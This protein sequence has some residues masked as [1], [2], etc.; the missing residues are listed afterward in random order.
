MAMTS[1]MAK[2]TVSALAPMK[3]VEKMNAVVVR[4]QK[5]QRE[6]LSRRDPYMM[7]VD[8]ERNCYACRRFRHI[9]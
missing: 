5:G 6:G 1:D 8:R 2:K 4:G 9:A 3:R 7:E